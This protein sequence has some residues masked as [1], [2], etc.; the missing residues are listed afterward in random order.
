MC[1]PVSRGSRQRGF[2]LVELLVVIAIIGILIALLLPAVQAAREAARRS[3]CTNNLK[4]LGIGLHGYS[5]ANGMFPIFAETTP[6]TPLSSGG[7]SG[8]AWSGYSGGY[9]GPTGGPLVRLLPYIEQVALYNQFNLNYTTEQYGWSPKTVYGAYNPTRQD[10]AA[11][12][13]Y[14][15]Q[16][17]IPAY[18]CP[19]V[20][21]P[22]VFNVGFSPPQWAGTDY[23]VSVGTAGMGYQYGSSAL[24]AYYPTSPYNPTGSYNG[25]FNDSNGWQGDG[26]H[27]QGQSTN[28]VFQLGDWAA[29]FQDIGDGTANTIAMMEN[30]RHCSENIF[31]GGWVS[32]WYTYA[33]TKAPINFPTCLQEKDVNGVVINYNGWSYSGTWAPWS[34]TDA[35]QGAKSKHP[36]GAQVLFAD[37]S[38]HFLHENIDYETYQRMGSRRDGKTLGPDSAW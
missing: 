15:G 27:N 23:F 33:S 18:V 25:W 17:V 31:Y 30:P 14:L 11:P 20:N 26:W 3:Q 10:L 2:T 6:P 36:G 29:R 19:S 12:N 16:Q 22:M 21:Y 32:I 5:D 24:D 1:S 4:Q 13:Y 37:G 38:V 28:G 9:K 34:Q 35:A 8:I 7:Y